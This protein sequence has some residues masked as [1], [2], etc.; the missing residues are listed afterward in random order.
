MTSRALTTKQILIVPCPT[1]GAKRNKP[2]ELA[3]GRRRT[4]AHRERRWV[5]SDKLLFDEAAQARVAKNGGRATVCV[6]CEN[7]ERPH[8]GR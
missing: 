3:S 1:C 7:S 8:D 2:C 5:A 6:R 4:E